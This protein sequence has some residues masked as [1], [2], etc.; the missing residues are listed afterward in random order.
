M[1]RAKEI[2][3]SCLADFS[4]EVFLQAIERSDNA[5]GTALALRLERKQIGARV[6]R[7]DFALQ[8]ALGFK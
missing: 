6:G 7:I 5:E 2:D 4:F 1:E 8:E 3:E